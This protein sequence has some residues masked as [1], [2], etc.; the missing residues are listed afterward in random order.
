[1]MITALRYLSTSLE[2]YLRRADVCIQD[3]GATGLLGICSHQTW[4]LWSDADC[5]EPAGSM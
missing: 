4:T 5:R 3:N 2:T 1:M